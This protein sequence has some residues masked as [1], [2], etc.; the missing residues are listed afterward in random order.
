MDGD[1]DDGRYIWR[2]TQPGRQVGW[3]NQADRPR[4]VA[5]NVMTGVF[6]IALGVFVFFSAM[7]KKARWLAAS[8]LCLVLM[9][10]VIR[11]GEARDDAHWS[12]VALITLTLA[13][14]LFFVMAVIRREANLAHK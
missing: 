2:P 8:A 11:F 14:T 3:A 1:A 6:L 13:A 4:F 7:W 12:F 5:H 9:G 10:S